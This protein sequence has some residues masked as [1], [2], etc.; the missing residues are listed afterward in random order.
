MRRSLGIWVIGLSLL[1]V[2][3]RAHAGAVRD[4]PGF[5]TQAFA[6]CD[7]AA[8]G[9]S[10]DSCTPDRL[11][12]QQI[13]FTVDFFGLQSSAVFVNNNGNLT[14]GEPL[15]AFTPE[16]L[17]SSAAGFR[18]IAP[19]WA[20]VDTRGDGSGVVTYGN[21]T[22]EGRPAFGVNWIGVGYYALQVSPTNSFQ[23]VL[24][25]RSDVGPGDFDIEFNYD[26]ILWEAGDGDVSDPA[27]RGGLALGPGKAAR[28]GYASRTAAFELPGSGEPG[29][30]L[31]GNRLTG[32]TWNSFQSTQPGRYVFQVR[33][34]QASACTD[35]ALCDDGNPC[36]TESCV[37]RPGA[38]VG[39]CTY[40][41]V[42]DGE[43]CD[44]GD[45]C[46]DKEVCSAGRCAG[47]G[48]S[49]EDG[50]PCTVDVCDPA[51]GLCGNPPA[52]EGT[53]CDDGDGCTDASICSGGEC[54]PTGSR[55]CE[56]Q[57]GVP[58][59]GTRKASFKVACLDA[60][61]G[62]VCR[63][64]LYE[65][66][67]AATGVT[68]AI[69]SGRPSLFGFTLGRTLARPRRKVVNRK[70]RAA[71]VMKL[72]PLAKA[73]IKQRG[74]AQAILE[75]SVAEPGEPARARQDFLVFLRNRRR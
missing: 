47:R 29:A 11:V 35:D 18:M 54:R 61:P 70:G 48:K 67:P 34:G 36:T 71:F 14:F 45:A 7:D 37:R 23:V 60:A 56:F 69:A 38:T 53:S 19:F 42:R 28:I 21:D 52:D 22:V 46:T 17:V 5:R 1:T 24:V 25:D 41:S 59:A 58:A 8:P 12:P 73:A 43:A 20:D 63:A 65:A 6:P 68:Q 64:V 50:N 44:D 75:T 4:L 49:C 3:V 57:V 2:A 55:S 9:D 40:A 72:N 51:T 16:P 62:A 66:V 27:G 26:R 74:T 33:G 15:D 10:D 39:D 13:G 30:F 31:D 32:L